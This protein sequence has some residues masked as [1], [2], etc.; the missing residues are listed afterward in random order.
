[1][2]SS[3]FSSSTPGVVVSIVGFCDTEAR[4]LSNEMRSAVAEYLTLVASG[5][6]KC[7]ADAGL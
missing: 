1:M 4:K 3:T 7:R 2:V 5:A 6:G